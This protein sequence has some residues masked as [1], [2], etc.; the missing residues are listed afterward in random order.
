M[1]QDVNTPDGSSPEDQRKESDSLAD[2][3]AH[4]DE[5]DSP[6]LKNEKLSAALDSLTRSDDEPAP[7]EDEPADGGGEADDNQDPDEPPAE[8][9]ADIP[10]EPGDEKVDDELDDE[11]KEAVAAKAAADKAKAAPKTP[12]DPD[13]KELANYSPAAQNRIRELIKRRKAT[14]KEVETVKLKAAYRDQLEARLTEAK[15][16]PEAWDQWADLG[17]LIQTAPETAAKVL[18]TMAE[19]LGYAAVPKTETTPGELDKDL[20]ELVAAD[21]MT[22]KA[23]KAIQA[24]RTPAKPAPK[25]PPMPTGQQTQMR[26]APSLA[27]PKETG[28]QIMARLDKEF[29][30][31]YPDQWGQVGAGGEYRASQV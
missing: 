21:E 19:S 17:F 9:D 25:Q 18:G 14:E 10:A 23:A 30:A 11:A 6:Y 15:M 20:K 16:T 27:A 13:Q 28:E 12:V 24:T 7:K 2:E 1:P 29:A 5:V 4:L 3:T 31:A 22:E 26:R 8:G